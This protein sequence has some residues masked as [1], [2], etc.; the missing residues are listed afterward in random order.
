MKQYL[1]AQ[2]STQTKGE[3]IIAPYVA[4]EMN[5]FHQLILYIAWKCT[6]CLISFLQNFLSLKTRK[7][8]AAQAMH[9]L[10]FC[11][12]FQGIHIRDFG[13]LT[14]LFLRVQ[15][16]NFPYK[17]NQIYNIKD[18]IFGLWNPSKYK[19]HAEFC[20]DTIP[21]ILAQRMVF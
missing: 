9:S 20:S 13:S 16:H 2:F 17:N 4:F 8:K 5:S 21:E 3:V 7:D 11:L 18:T 19:E 6:L 15:S 1:K 14:S 10:L 12:C